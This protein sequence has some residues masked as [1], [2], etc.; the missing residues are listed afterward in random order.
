MKIRVSGAPETI[1]DGAVQIA[2]VVRKLR[3]IKMLDGG[4]L[5]TLAVLSLP[6]SL[7]ANAVGGSVFSFPPAD[8][9]T[10]PSIALVAGGQGPFTY[11]WTLIAS[12]GGNLPVITTP[13]VSTT[14]F[15]KPL[16]GPGLFYTDSFRCTVTDSLG[17]T[18]SADVT[19]TYSNL[20]GRVTSSPGTDG[21]TFSLFVNNA[22]GAGN[23]RDRISV[24][25]AP[26][27]TSMIGG[28]GPFTYRWI[29]VSSSDGDTPR[30]STPNASSTTFTKSGVK[31][32]RS[33]AASFGCTVTDST[34]SE[35]FIVVGATFRNVYGSN[36]SSF[37]LAVN[38]VTGVGNSITP[39]TVTTP[40]SI[41]RAGGQGP[42]TYRWTLISSGGGDAAAISTPNS[43]NTK[44]VKPNVPKGALYI[45]NFRCTVTNSLGETLTADITAVFKNV[46]D[47]DNPDTGDA[48][49]SLS[50]NDVVGAANAF[51]Q[52]VATTTA[53]TALVTG[54]VGPFTYR[55][56]FVSSNGGNAPRIT[57]QNT[58]NTTFIKSGVPIGTFYVDNFRCTATDSQ[59]ATASVAVE[60]SFFNI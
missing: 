33:Y 5:R 58:S 31:K 11:E 43:S 50:A 30:I 59:G 26:S 47:G 56:E 32:G 9:T 42:F 37:T 29:L 48:T 8:V 44:F 55:W 3:T 20:Q 6:I 34:G 16:V 19:A 53:S 13:N 10:D 57:S 7:S 17:E 39:I 23:S 28:Q 12:G 38:S 49:F 21:E 45:D 54:G 46:Y 40:D 15:V 1:V 52:G 35:A 51:S 22:S 60:A 41:C 18:A 25:T 4:V 24:V 14:T 36:D 27:I 2:G